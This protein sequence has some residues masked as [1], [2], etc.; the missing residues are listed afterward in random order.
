[1]LFDG[2]LSR[3]GA[4][5]GTIRPMRFTKE[6]FFTV[7]GWTLVAL[8]A[9]AF[10]MSVMKPMVLTASD[11]GR[12]L[13]NGMLF[14]DHGEIAT[15]NLYSYT[16]P[17]FPFLNHHWG[18]GVFFELARRF[19]GF[20]G[21]SMFGLSLVVLTAV[22]Y[23]RIAWL[24]G[25]LWLA[26]ASAFL[27]LPIFASRTEVRPELFSYLFS[28]VYLWI[29][30]GV[31]KGTL[32]PKALI[33][34]PVLMLAW[35][36]LHI[37]FFLGIGWMGAFF[38]DALWGAWREP[39]NRY[40]RLR[41]AKQLFVAL[42]ASCAITPLNPNGWRGAVYPLFIF[43][44]Y[45]YAVAEN[46]TPLAIERN[47]PYPPAFYLRIAS[48]ALFVSWI[49]RLWRDWR[50]SR[51]TDV[52]IVILTLFATFIAWKAI[53]NFSVFSYVTMVSVAFA[54]ADVDLRERFG[55]LGSWLQAAIPAAVLALLVA[56]W[57]A[58]WNSVYR[59]FGLGVSPGILQSIDFFKE[60]GLTGPIM[61]NYDIGGFLTYGLFPEERVFVDNRPEAYPG[62]FFTEILL[63]MQ[64]NDDAWL[65]VDARVGF[66]T[67]FFY[68]HD[69]TRWGQGFMIRRLNDP[70]WAPVY[71][72]NFVIIIAKRV[73]EFEDIIAEYELPK[74]MFDVVPRNR[75][76]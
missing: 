61:N 12:H 1:M 8:V 26:L 23:L 16:H 39:E 14:L 10:G 56:L 41:F 64:M 22:L 54:W 37:Y 55:R 6:H 11:L 57:P 59:T 13:M 42:L 29:L 33:A 58:Y 67:I 49:W 73:P 68:R 50:A 38:L 46:Q 60:T 65:K 53:R 72:D 63:P 7:G 69:A 17:D 24:H 71:V 28:A 75:G 19:R 21:V 48:A 5:S 30:L 62:E 47:G 40:E 27:V 32:S 52:A 51:T 20:I 25:R 18:S 31:R 35:V 45:A 9:V 2:T 70:A 74:S 66:K 15:T 36:N 34:L 3:S 44:N 4:P 43:E 76:R